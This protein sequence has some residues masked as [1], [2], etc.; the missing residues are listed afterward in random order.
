[1]DFSATSKEN[2]YESA[3]TIAAAV[4]GDDNYIELLKGS[5]DVGIDAVEVGEVDP[6]NVGENRVEEGSNLVE[7]EVEYGWPSGC[8][9]LTCGMVTWRR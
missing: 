1:M 5:L 9:T 4:E 2:F 7:Q 3:E 6:A 8:S